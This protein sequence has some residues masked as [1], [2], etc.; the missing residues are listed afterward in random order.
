M[1]PKIASFPQAAG[2][3]LLAL[4]GLS[5]LLRFLGHAAAHTLA[6]ERRRARPLFGHWPVT[7]PTD[8]RVASA[9]P[10]PALA[11]GGAL[12]G[13]WVARSLDRSRVTLTPQRVCRS[14]TKSRRLACMTIPPLICC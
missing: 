3:D 14:E 1:P 13:L 2:L 8:R 11:R 12:N 10:E 6:R 9:A 5:R 4:F 7:R